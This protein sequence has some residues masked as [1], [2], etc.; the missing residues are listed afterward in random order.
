[1]KIKKKLNIKTFLFKSLNDQ[2]K[3]SVATINHIAFQT[4]LFV[5]FVAFD[6]VCFLK[7]ARSQTFFYIEFFTY[8]HKL[9]IYLF[10]NDDHDAIRFFFVKCLKILLRDNVT[11][12]IKR[13]DEFQKTKKC[14]IIDLISK[15]DEEKKNIAFQKSKKKVSQWNQ[16]SELNIVKRMKFSN[17]FFFFVKFVSVMNEE[18][19]NDVRKMKKSFFHF[20][21][22]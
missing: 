21:F 1:M 22:A 9:F 2:K 17:K 13:N 16:T 6:C 15:I 10:I 8:K 11:I 12:K 20:F 3:I 7:Y 19:C 4:N 14:W 18:F 5:F